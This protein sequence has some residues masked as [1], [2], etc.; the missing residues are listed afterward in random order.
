MLRRRP[1]RYGR[2]EHI[3]HGARGIAVCG[4]FEGDVQIGCGIEHVEQGPQREAVAAIAFEPEID[5]HSLDPGGERGRIDLGQVLGAEIALQQVFHLHSTA[6]ADRADRARRL[7]PAA[8][9]QNC[10]GE[11]Q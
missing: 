9:R 10:F 2:R 3:H 4:I 7:H 1:H 11:R 5:A 8:R 6:L